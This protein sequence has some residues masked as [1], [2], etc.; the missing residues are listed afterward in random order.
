VGGRNKLTEDS[1]RGR[2]N[3]ERRRAVRIKQTQEGT[4]TG[5]K[6]IKNGRVVCVQQQRVL[7]FARCCNTHRT[8]RAN[9]FFTFSF[10]TMTSKYTIISQI[11]TLLH[12]STL[13]CHPQGAC[14]QIPCQVTPVFQMMLLV[15]QFTI[16]MFHMRFMQVLVL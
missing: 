8:N 12:V 2:D 6:W 15:I 10:C 7:D 11:I 1:Y 9:A 3:R 14:N 4:P 5:R 16:K 13:S